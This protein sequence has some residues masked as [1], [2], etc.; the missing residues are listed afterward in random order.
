MQAPLRTPRTL[1]S[2]RVCWKWEGTSLLTK[3]PKLHSSLQNAHQRQDASAAW[4]PE[5]EAWGTPTNSL[6]ASAWQA[7][8]AEEVAGNA[9]PTVVG[10]GASPQDSSPLLGSQGTSGS[11]RGELKSP[12]PF[13]ICRANRG[14]V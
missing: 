3:I 14:R 1:T 10:A 2:Q 4:T 9:S 12:H 5:Q 8:E 7:G 13:G 11:G 6:P